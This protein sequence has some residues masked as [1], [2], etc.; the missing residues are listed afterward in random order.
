MSNRPGS[1][2]D[3]QA[4]PDESV[5]EDAAH[6]RDRLSES[7]RQRDE[8]RASYQR[9]RQRTPVRILMALSSRIDRARGWVSSAAHAA[10]RALPRQ[11]LLTW[12]LRRERSPSE[13]NSNAF[14]TIVVPTRDGAHRLR[15]LFGAL[16]KHTRHQSVEIIVVDNASEDDTAAVVSGFTKWPS[17]TIRNDVN[18]SFSFSCNQGAAEALGDVILFLNDDTE[19]ATAGWLTEML[20]AVAA[21]DQVAA[22]ALL[23]YPSGRHSRDRASRPLAIQHLGI[24]FTWRDGRPQPINLGAGEAPLRRA[25][26]PVEVPAATAACLIVRRSAFEAVG[27]FTLGYRYGWED[28]DLCLKL[29]DR[30]GRIM[31]APNAVLFHQEFGTQDSLSPETR[32]DNYLHNSMLFTGHWGARL[33]RLMW[34]D[35]LARRQFW[36]AKPTGTIAL[37][38]TDLRE[39]EGYGDWYTAHELGTALEAKG[40][41]TTYIERRNDA[42]HRPDLSADI[43]ISLLPQYDPRLS[44]TGAMTVAWV[45][46][47]VER[48]IDNPGFDHYMLVASAT[49]GFV[50]SIEFGS[51]HTPVPMPLATNLSRFEGGAATAEYAAD[52]T[53]TANRW[54]TERS[55]S[56]ALA[57]MSARVSVYGK[58]WEDTAVADC[59]RGSIGYGELPS[60]YKSSALVVDDTVEPNRPALNSRIF[61]ALAAGS[62]VLSDSEYGS[63]EWFD[64]LLPTYAS[65]D[66]LIALVDH[67]VAD[68]TGR[69]ALVAKLRKIVVERHTYDQRADQLL[70]ALSQAVTTPSIGIRISASVARADRW[71]DT[72][73][74][75]DAARA[76][77]RTGFATRISLHDDWSTPEHHTFDVILALR[78]LHQYLPMPGTI[79]VLWVISHPDDVTPEELSAYDLV[80]VAGD[81]L[82]EEYGPHC[83]SAPK[84][85]LQATDPE[86]FAPG[87]PDASLASDVLFVGN[88][89]GVD[90]PSVRHAIDAQLSLTVYG[91]G[92]QD[93]VPAGYLKGENFPQRAPT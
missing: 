63:K 47:W 36:T 57:E 62:L 30:G 77:R 85:L 87:P 74:A 16:E 71:G 18:Q 33:S 2:R 35:T 69:A 1:A 60:V 89:R 45:R 88:S 32:A 25:G 41:R 79:N 92:W 23:V 28:T 24:G 42:W 54:G 46:N 70:N 82:I 66:D 91:S 14:V 73:F 7:I 49:D 8:A 37:T 40:W 75:R 84:L 11:T 9:L 83:A 10:L 67:Y 5:V 20:K 68:S 17:K 65:H 90:R 26:P 76:L 64:G 58:G 61:D 3:D 44:P 51:T 72:H 34:L 19:P 4:T 38:V 6:L 78:G 53:V 39:S 56:Q 12:R 81:R 55:M 59:W 93:R 50:E 22:G 21:D 15:N 27:G 86:R 29:R 52:V 31:L 13:A 48:W 80:Y 43:V